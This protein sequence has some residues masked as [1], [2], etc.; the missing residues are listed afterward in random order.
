ML[1]VIENS[2]DWAVFGNPTNGC[3]PR[4]LVPVSGADLK[5]FGLVWDGPTAEAP[6]AGPSV[7]SEDG[8][9]HDAV[10]CKYGR[11]NPCEVLS[12]GLPVGLLTAG[13]AR[14]HLVRAHME[15]HGINRD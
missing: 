9:K 6:L 2:E 11:S 7:A 5:V 10:V 12:C 8:S 14:V 13:L 15:R 4:S 1:S 3:P